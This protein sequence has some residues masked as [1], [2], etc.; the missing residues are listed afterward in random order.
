[1]YGWDVEVRG[2]TTRYHK[3]LYDA[4]GNHVGS[5]SISRPTKQTG[6]KKKAALYS[7]KQVSSQV[8]AAKTSGKA[9]QVS[10][11]IRM[12]IGLLRKQLKKPHLLE[13]MTA[14]F[15]CHLEEWICQ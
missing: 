13:D 2:S 8:L 14:E 10:T 4:Y 7:F 11:S 6:K 12:K 5:I 9:A 15:R 3:N 1:M